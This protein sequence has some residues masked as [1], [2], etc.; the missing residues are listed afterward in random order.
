MRG[1]FAAGKY[2]SRV[3]EEEKKAPPAAPENG[4]QAKTPAEVEKSISRKLQIDV[5]CRPASAASTEKPKSHLME[6]TYLCR[7]AIILLLLLLWETWKAERT[8]HF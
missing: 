3:P 7:H 6:C 4:E 1:G 5:P 8:F 2:L